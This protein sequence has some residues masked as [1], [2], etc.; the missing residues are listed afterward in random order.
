MTPKTQHGNA[1]E[2][3]H[4]FMVNVR[5]PAVV[6]APKLPE[7]SATEPNHPTATTIT[8]TKNTTTGNW[9]WAS[10]GEEGGCGTGSIYDGGGGAGDR[11][12]GGSGGPFAR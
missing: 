9:A 7:D 6:A 3:T 2:C 11:D 10:S 4:G 1:T 12:D 5:E 8:G